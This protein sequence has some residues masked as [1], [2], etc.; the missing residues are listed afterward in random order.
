MASVNFIR[1]NKA[2]S[3]SCTKKLL[4]DWVKQEVFLLIFHVTAMQEVKFWLML[5]MH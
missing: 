4:R 3:Y 2:N 5:S 1:L